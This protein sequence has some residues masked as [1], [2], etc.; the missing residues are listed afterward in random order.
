MKSETVVF[1][2]ILI[3]LTRS[4]YRVTF[5][6]SSGKVIVNASYSVFSTYTLLSCVRKCKFQRKCLSINFDTIGR[7]CYLNYKGHL[8]PGTQMENSGHVRS[9]DVD[10]WR[11]E[12]LYM[13]SCSNHRCRYDLIC[14]QG[15]D[16][17]A[18]YTCIQDTQCQWNDGC[19]GCI[20]DNGEM[21]QPN[22]RDFTPIGCYYAA[23]ANPGFLSYVNMRPQ[24]NWYDIGATVRAC[25]EETRNRMLQF[26]GLE[27]YG[28]CYMRNDTL[29]VSYTIVAVNQCSEK[30]AFGVGAADI[31]FF[32]QLI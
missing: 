12:D 20:Q 6:Y 27:F 32:Y 5:N 24:I 10:V 30:C 26:F 29:D 25:A 3:S 11:D 2:L 31:I 13:G 1:L 15:S 22:T 18:P 21:I 23:G 7:K 16:H 17:T 19:S 28:E 9:Y 14:E 8:T 4:C